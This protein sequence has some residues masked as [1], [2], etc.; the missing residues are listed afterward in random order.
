M[1]VLL[2]YSC[3]EDSFRNKFKDPVDMLEEKEMEKQVKESDLIIF[4]GG[5]DIDPKRYKEVDET[6]DYYDNKRDA[7]E[8]DLMSTA[9]A[10]NKPII[11]TCRG[12][13]LINVFFGGTLHQDIIWYHSNHNF[14]W[15]SN[16]LKDFFPR[17]NSMH[18]QGIKLLAKEFTN[19]GETDDGLVECIF[20]SKL[21]ILAFQFHPELINS[22]FW[23]EITN[24]DVLFK[25]LEVE[26]YS[27]SKE[28][29]LNIW[30]KK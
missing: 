4:T 6:F 2:S 29:I 8:Y 16:I 13:Q 17:T 11:G 26:Q 5:S 12:L 20:N 14:K 22:K 19:L 23:E 10:F 7:I 3:F 9:L 21:K 27:K 25:Q 24:P 15:K 28:E 1:K 18:H 30:Q